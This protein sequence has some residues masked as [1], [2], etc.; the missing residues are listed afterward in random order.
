MTGLLR[1]VAASLV[2]VVVTGC[3]SS[4]STLVRSDRAGRVIYQIS[5]QQAF[6]IALEA[7]AA[8]YPKQS[9]D[10]IVRKGQRGYNVDERAWTDYWSHRL[11]VIPAVG[12][13][14]NGN[15]VQG[16]VYEYEGGG[17]MWATSE[18]KTALIELIRSRLDATGRG[19]VV[20]NIRGGQYETDGKAYLG[21]KRDARDIPPTLQPLGSK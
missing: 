12:T 8:L 16:Y 19:T 7:Y 3:A 5:E 15:E 17:T 1:I 18:R 4:G 10:D 9:V 6:T 21:L 14:A 20:T 13:D 2:V 11:W